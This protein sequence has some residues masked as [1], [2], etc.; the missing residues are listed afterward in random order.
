MKRRTFHR[1]LVALPAALALPVSAQSATAQSARPFRLAFVST[2]RQAAPSPNLE[3]FR[4]GMREL[5]YAEGRNLR[6]D[7]GWGEGSVEQPTKVVLV[8]DPTAARA[9]GLVTPASV[10]ARADGLIE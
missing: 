8:V 7:T 3:A 6:L 5:G 2:Q 10:L 9:M 1:T 4:G